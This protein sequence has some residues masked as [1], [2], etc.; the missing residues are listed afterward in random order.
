MESE[1]LYDDLACYTLSHEDPSFIHQHVVDA[2]AVQNADEHTAPI[3]IV[4][5][6]AGLYLHIEKGFTGR[7]VQLTHMKMANKRKAWPRI[8][9]PAYRGS[10]T[11][12][13]VVAVPP[14]NQRDTMIHQWCRSVWEACRDV[15]NDIITLLVDELN[16]TSRE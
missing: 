10:I 3:A 5:G 4:F 2:Y 6:L 1:R 8:T 16:L 7:Q 14:G 13:D 15:H 11:V 9:L 12:S